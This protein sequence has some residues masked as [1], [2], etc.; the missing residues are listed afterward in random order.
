MLT[1]RCSNACR[2]CLYRCSPKNPDE[3]MSLEMGERVFKALA[4]EPALHSIHLAGGEATLRFD[5]LLDIVRLCVGTGLPLDYLETNAGWCGDR[6]E[7]REKLIRLREAGLRAILVS[8]SMFHN[9]F[10]PFSHTR[11]CVEEARRVF[12]RAGAIVW[13][14]HLYE[15]LSQ[16]PEEDKTHTLREFCEG[17][18][19][20]MWDPKIPN[21]YQ[22]IPGGRAPE[23]LR[24]CYSPRPPESFR[25]ARCRSEIMSVTHFHIDLYGNLFTGFCAGLVAG[26]I[27]GLHPLIEPER[28][29]LLHLLSEE[30]PHGLYKMASE[31]HGYVPLEGG[32]VS[33]CD[34][35]YRVRRHLHDA[36]RFPELRPD[37]Y[38]AG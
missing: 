4:D 19:I 25:S 28:Y 34:L 12:G 16:M 17:L 36:G 30:G 6:E 33:K 18:D 29:P 3:W 27:D 20:P 31:E 32:Y 8:A 38:Y 11:N 9:E 10:I 5:L 14:P 22:V 15:I 1:Y 35:C 7:T 23:A 24:K 21:L 13:L 37:A 2:H 26:T